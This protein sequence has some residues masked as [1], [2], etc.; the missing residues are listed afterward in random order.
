MGHMIITEAALA[1][2]CAL[3]NQ[4]IREDAAMERR[5]DGMLYVPMPDDILANLNAA[6]LPGEDDSQLALRAF[7]T[8]VARRRTTDGGHR[9][10]SLSR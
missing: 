6:R 8:V 4:K 9:R 2:I 10:A 5:A 3:T 7:E 1:A